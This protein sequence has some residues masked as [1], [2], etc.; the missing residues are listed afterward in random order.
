[1]SITKSL[2]GSVIYGKFGNA[3]PQGRLLK[4]A[5]SGILAEKLGFSVF[6]EKHSAQVIEMSTIFDN[7]S[8]ISSLSKDVFTLEVKELSLFRSA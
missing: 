4:K 2:D 5:R 3:D 6:V 8:D 1:M 7:P